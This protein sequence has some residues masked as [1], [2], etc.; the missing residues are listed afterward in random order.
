MPDG[1]EP[2]FVLTVTDEEYALI[3]ADLTRAHQF[4]A[5]LKATSN[6]RG[7]TVV[8]FLLGE[9]SFSAERLTLLG[10]RHPNFK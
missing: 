10:G 5:A 4:L 7:L 1:D 8:P 6:A 2:V 3:A 9:I